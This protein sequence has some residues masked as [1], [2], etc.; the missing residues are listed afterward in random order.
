MEALPPEMVQRRGYF[1]MLEGLGRGIMRLFDEDESRL[2][3][4][5]DSRHASAILEFPNAA[6]HDDLPVRS[7]SG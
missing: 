7:R 5:T 2:V 3:L 1:L 4:H 6:V